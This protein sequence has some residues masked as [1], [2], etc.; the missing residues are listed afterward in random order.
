[1]PPNREREE[2]GTDEKEKLAVHNKARRRKRKR[3]K[4][5]DKI[6]GG[7]TPRG[8]N[9]GLNLERFAKNKALLAILP[10]AQEVDLHS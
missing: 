5:N 3:N 8:T 1:L 2:M 10:P 7:A 9:M 4:G 6:Q